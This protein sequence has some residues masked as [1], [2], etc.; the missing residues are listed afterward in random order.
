MLRLLLASFWLLVASLHSSFAFVAPRTSSSSSHSSPVVVVL[1]M[2]TATKPE[3]EVISQPD[4]AFLEKK[5][6]CK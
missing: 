2:S 5:G 3:I 6:V 4:Q 1:N